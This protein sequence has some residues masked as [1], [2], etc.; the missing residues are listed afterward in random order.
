ML[1]RRARRVGRGPVGAWAAAC[2]VGLALLAGLVGVEALAQNVSLGGGGVTFNMRRPPPPGQGALPGFIF[3]S[4]E[5]QLVDPSF[6]DR[7]YPISVNGWWGFANQRGRIVV[8]PQ[9]DWCD[10]V[11]DGVYRVVVDGW[12]YYL[13][14]LANPLPHEAANADGT[15]RGFAFADRFADGV[16]VVGGEGDFY[17]IDK[18]GRRVGDVSADLILRMSERVNAALVD[19]RVGYLD[20]GG[21]WLIEPSYPV[22]RRFHQGMAAVRLPGNAPDAIGPWAIINKR[23]SVQWADRSSRVER[24]G[25]FRDGMMRVKVDGRWGYLDRAYR[26]AIKPVYLDAR[27][28]SGGRAAVRDELG[29][30]LIDRKGRAQG[31]DRLEDL[32]GFPFEGRVSLAESGGRAGLVGR[33]QRWVVQ[34]AYPWA[35][36]EF[37]LLVRAG[38]DRPV[39]DFRYVDIAGGRV[40]DPRGALEGVSDLRRRSLALAVSR[41]ELVLPRR[42]P[43][44]PR[45]D[46]TA[47]AYPPEY[48][49]DLQLPQPLLFEADPAAGVLR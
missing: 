1:T 38:L 27:P 13:R 29:W 33:T 36:A 6:D 21:R 16:A 12:T 28:F 37:R 17:L 10:Y 22:G 24:L 15:P 44:P 40:F 46:P 47:P 23:G 14:L 49:E 30:F 45:R 9:W 26:V 34:P 8:W 32:F 31:R 35:Y 4:G 19:G 20:R 3:Q 18:S 48:L 39:G 2:R 42:V 5:A 43:P 41:G 7:L 25:D 11:H